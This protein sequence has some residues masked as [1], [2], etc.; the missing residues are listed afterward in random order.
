MAFFGDVR[1]ILSVHLLRMISGVNLNWEIVHQSARQSPEEP[2]ENR[3]K[4][5]KDLLFFRNLLLYLGNPFL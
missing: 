5:P 4:Q 2:A 3:K 1:A